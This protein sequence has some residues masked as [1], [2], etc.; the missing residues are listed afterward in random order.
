MNW[1]HRQSQVTQEELKDFSYNYTHPII[2]KF[3]I[4]LS[5]EAVARICFVKKVFLEIS[6]NWQ[7]NTCVRVSFLIKLQTE[8]CNFIK[9]ETLTQVFS[10]EFWEI[11]KNTFSYRTPPVAAVSSRILNFLRLNFRTC[12]RHFKQVWYE[13][14]FNSLFMGQLWQV[15]LELLSIFM[16]Y[17]VKMDCLP[18]KSCFI[19]L[20]SFGQDQGFI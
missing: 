3:K 10:C 2:Y 14:W 18:T 19:I 9:K 13:I 12:L 11:S 16:V 15:I 4:L 5:S 20:F 8:A 6:Q 7:E 1:K 17:N